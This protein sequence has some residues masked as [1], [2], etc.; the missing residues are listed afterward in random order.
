MTASHRVGLAITEGLPLYSVAI[1]CDVFGMPRSGLP[2]PWYELFVCTP[3]GAPV[4]TASGFIPEDRCD[5]DALATADT[6]VIPAVSVPDAEPQPDPELVAAVRRA[7]DRGAR[8]VSFC[9]GAFVLA[10]AGIVD[11]RPVATH[12]RH[13]E[14]LAAR[15]PKVRVDP[16][17]L[18]VDDGDV[19]T[20]AGS[21]ASLDLCLHLVRR[22]HGVGVANLLAKRLVAPVHRPGGQA[23][24][25][26]TAVNVADDDG[27]APL[28]HWALANLSRPLSVADLARHA[29]LAE[30]TL[31]RRFHESTGTTPMKWLRAQRI[32]RARELLESTTLPVEQVGDA[33]GLGSPA[34]FR[35]HFAELVGVPPSEYRRTF[36]DATTA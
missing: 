21:S 29:N 5:L 14:S 31:V 35:H 19:L 10:A 15:Y 8:I 33:C 1:A 18:Y 30:R 12:W 16:A 36:R 13:A 32:D 26:D 27:L 7:Y 17:V 20:S 6:V 23:Q 25:V 24:F 22:D 34:N 9:T 3:R 4:R 28:L 2:D 11:G